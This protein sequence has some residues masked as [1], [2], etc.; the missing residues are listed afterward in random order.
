MTS[1]SFAQFPFP[2]G[3]SSSSSPASRGS[4]PPWR[5][6]GLSVLRDF[7]SVTVT[8]DGLSVGGAKPFAGDTLLAMRQARLVLDVGSVLRY[9]KSGDRIVVREI[10]LGA[11]SVHLRVL[12]DGTQNWDIARPRPARGAGASAAVGVTLRDLRISGGT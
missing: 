2:D 3:H 9:L 11:P 6:V 5:G 10:A 7:P 4:D 12:A 1:S 8:L